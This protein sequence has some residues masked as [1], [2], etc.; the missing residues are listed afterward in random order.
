[1]FYFR[2]IAETNITKW[3]TIL[4]ENFV[5]YMPITPYRSFAPSQVV[6]GQRM[7]QGKGQNYD[8]FVCVYDV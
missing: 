5:F 7:I 4:D 1:M 8:L 2:A 3:S 6:N